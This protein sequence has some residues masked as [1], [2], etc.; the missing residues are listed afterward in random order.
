MSWTSAAQWENPTDGGRL[1]RAR[2]SMGRRSCCRR[3]LPV[4]ASLGAALLLLCAA[5]R[6]LRPGE[7]AGL[8]FRFAFSAGAPLGATW[9]LPIVLGWDVSGGRQAPSTPSLSLVA[10]EMTIA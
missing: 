6:A 10:G 7:C 9:H 4:V 1:P 5:P 2:R 8:G 3:P